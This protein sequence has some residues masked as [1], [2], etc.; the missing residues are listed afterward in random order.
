MIAFVR[1][2]YLVERL[3]TFKKKLFH[4]MLQV[5]FWKSLDLD[6]SN[7]DPRA[8]TTRH[9]GRDRLAIEPS[10]HAANSGRLVAED[11]HY[12]LVYRAV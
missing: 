3:Q 6:F 7:R 12:Q 2:Y 1:L 11:I 9:C 4:H 5:I 10:T 8:N